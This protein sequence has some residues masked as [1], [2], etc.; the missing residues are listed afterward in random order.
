MNFYLASLLH[1]EMWRFF[2]TEKAIKFK[3][4]YKLRGASRI[5]IGEKLYQRRT[6]ARPVLSFSQYINT[7]A[8]KALFQIGYINPYLFVETIFFYYLCRVADSY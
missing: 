1:C 7:A 2:K 3:K 6:T 4:P 5:H 8:G